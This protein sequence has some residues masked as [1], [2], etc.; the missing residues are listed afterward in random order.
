MKPMRRSFVIVGTLCLVLILAAGLGAD[1][2]SSHKTQVKFEG[3]LGRVIGMFAGKSGKEGIVS[4]VAI[5]GD[6]MMSVTEQNGE[7]VDL[8]AEKVYNI[9]FKAKSYSVLTFAEFRQRWEEAQAKMKEQAAQQRPAD[10][11]P[12]DAQFEMDFNVEKT[13]ERETINGYDCQKVVMTIAMRQ[14]GKT[15]E[16]GGMVMTNDMWMGPRIPALQE[17]AAFTMRYMKKLLGSDAETMARDMAQAMAMYPQMKAA[18][19][20][21]QKESGKLDGTAIRTVMKV[22]T[23][24]SAEQAQAKEDQPKVNIGGV[25]GKLGGLFGRK[26]KADEAPKEDQPAAAGAKN[27]A[28]FLTSTSELLNVSTAV[29]AEDVEIPAGFKLK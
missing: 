24:M 1:V 25:A 9:D 22:E 14:K 21:M 19:A 5:S 23:V 27:R 26:K 16:D 2:K 7:L 13:G 28:T 3:M 17:Q 18:M 8:A 10:Q 12:A 20:R 11:P 29:T 6:K 4:T 15:L